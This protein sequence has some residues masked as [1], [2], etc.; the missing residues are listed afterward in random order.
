M[1]FFLLGLTWAAKNI[2]FTRIIIPPS[3]RSISCAVPVLVPWAEP[4]TQALLRPCLVSPLALWCRACAVLGPGLSYLA[5][6]TQ[7]AWG[8]CHIER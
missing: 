6:Y 4:A 3:C 1:F 7:T 2:K 5:I 8:R